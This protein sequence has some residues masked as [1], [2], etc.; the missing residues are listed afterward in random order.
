MESMNTQYSEDMTIR[1]AVPPE[2]C[3]PVGGGDQ[4]PSC[5]SYPILWLEGASEY[6]VLSL[7]Q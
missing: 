6:K 3:K 7:A 2:D 1:I 5:L 4:G